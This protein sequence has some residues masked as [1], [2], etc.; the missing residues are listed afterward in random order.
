MQRLL[1]I[2][3]LKELPEQVGKRLLLMLQ[4]STLDDNLCRPRMTLY[5][6]NGSP[7]AAEGAALRQGLI[8]PD[9]STA[10]LSCPDSK[11]PPAFAD[12]PVHQ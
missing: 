5:C 12:C 7:E 11:R 2:E 3:V 9:C 10:D 6:S 1:G 8:P 4:C